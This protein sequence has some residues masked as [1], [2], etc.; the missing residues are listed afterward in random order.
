VLIRE[1]TESDAGACLDL[2]LRVHGRDG[3]PLHVPV[4]EVPAFFTVE[5]EAG[6]WVAEQAGAVVGHVALRCPPD[7]PTMVVAERAT[8]L[9]PDR[10]AM[11]SRLFIAP[12][13]RGTG[14]GRTLLRH[15]T[16]QARSRGR[17]AVLDVGQRLT[18]AVDLYESEGWQRVDALHLPLDR[19]TVLDLWVYV[20]PEP[21]TAEGP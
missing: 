13:L 6:A 21:V 10:L 9:S 2:L 3:Y 15:A 12:E 20:S 5:H 18:A 14:L 7:D 8:G 4:A 19:D 11:V 1:R 17:R 16:G